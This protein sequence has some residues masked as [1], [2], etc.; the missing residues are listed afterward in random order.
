M[1]SRSQAI[2]LPSRI[3]LTALWRRYHRGDVPVL[4]LHGVLPDG[5]PGPFNSNGRFISLG[6]LRRYLD[7]LGGRYRF[8][9]LD[10]Y[11]D[12]THFRERTTVMPC[13]KC[14][15]AKDRL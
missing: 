5:L 10:G 13:I 4:F 7:L 2:A 12:H 6:L 3:G 11:L 8:M 15:L 9:A 1:I 14:G